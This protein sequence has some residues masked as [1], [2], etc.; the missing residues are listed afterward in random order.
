MQTWEVAVALN[1]FRIECYFLR[2]E[3]EGQRIEF[4]IGYKYTMK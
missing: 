3:G 1:S 2:G 4:K